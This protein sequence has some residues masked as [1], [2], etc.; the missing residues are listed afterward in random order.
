MV[1]PWMSTV[2]GGRSSAAS[3][4]A[5]AFVLSRIVGRFGFSERGWVPSPHVAISVA[6]EVRPTA[7]DKLLSFCCAVSVR[8]QSGQATLSGAAMNFWSKSCVITVGG[9]R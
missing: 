8:L 1:V 5:G 4:R 9:L 7:E 6:A 2:A 3:G